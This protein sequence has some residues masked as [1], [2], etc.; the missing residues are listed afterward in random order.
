MTTAMIVFAC[1][2]PGAAF[3]LGLEGE[4]IARCAEESE[5]KSTGIYFGIYNF[6]VK[7]L[8][9]L[10]LFFTGIL[11]DLGTVVAVRAMPICAGVLC[12]LGV[13]LYLTLK[14]AEKATLALQS[15]A[16]GQSA[17]IEPEP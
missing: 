4:A 1:A 3:I 7:A 10:A 12:V 2:G 5:F 6:I 15:A 16:A 8:N 17:P 11:A 14:R 13:V 9:G